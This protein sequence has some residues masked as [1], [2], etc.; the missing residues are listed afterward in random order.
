MVS[1]VGL[2]SGE[3][4]RYGKIVK[5]CDHLLWVIRQK[6]EPSLAILFCYGQIII[7]ITGQI[8]KNNIAIWSHRLIY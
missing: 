4:R 5:V 7:V 1:P 3:I 8:L 6:F 2:D